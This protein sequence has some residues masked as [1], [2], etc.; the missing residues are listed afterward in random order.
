MKLIC[1]KVI[2][3]ISI[4]ELQTQNLGIN[5]IYFAYGVW[6]SNEKLEI[7]NGTCGNV[8]VWACTLQ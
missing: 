2:R 5:N 6:Q 1:C 7:T 8:I 4:K 3:L